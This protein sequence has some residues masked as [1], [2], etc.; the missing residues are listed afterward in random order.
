MKLSIDYAYGVHPSRCFGLTLGLDILLPP[1]KCPLDCSWCPLGKTVDRT[2]TA[3]EQEVNLGKIVE[4]L[5]ELYEYIGT[6]ARKV[7]VW[8]F[9]DPLLNRRISEAVKAVRAESQADKVI[10]HTSGL[11]LP[12]YY[13][14]GLFEDVDEFV[15]PFEWASEI[16]LEFGWEPAVSITTFLEILSEFNRRYPGKLGLEITVF[17][18]AG[19]LTPSTESLREIAKQARRVGAERI[20]LKTINRFVSE[21]IHSVNPRLISEYAEILEEN[22]I[23]PVVCYGSVNFEPGIQKHGLIRLVYNHILRKP[24]SFRELRSIYGDNGVISAENLVTMKKAVKTA[25]E[26][27]VYY[28]GVI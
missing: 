23:K 25:W 12:Q 15:I 2:R 16:R 10:I 8:G 3:K 27:E 22:G 4:E 7:Y 6:L 9:G 19:S 14:S 11:L 26:K 28:R 17:K 18:F 21:K 24:L 1:K 13:S 5:K 20:Y